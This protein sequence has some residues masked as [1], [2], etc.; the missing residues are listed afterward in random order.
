MRCL[1]CAAQAVG[2]GCPDT[3][4]HIRRCSVQASIVP[5][6]SV[7]VLTAFASSTPDYNTYSSADSPAKAV[8]LYCGTAQW[9]PR[10]SQG[11]GLLACSGMQCSSVTGCQKHGSWDITCA[12]SDLAM[13]SLHKQQPST[14]QTC[15]SSRHQSQ[16][17][18]TSASTT[19]LL[20]V[21]ASRS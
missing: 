4:L 19:A 6:G 14:Q 18:C 12:V 17:A 7:T 9:V 1:G 16:S 3:Y 20:R 11:I 10:S 2:Q 8:S 21:N 15:A 13:Q 5:L